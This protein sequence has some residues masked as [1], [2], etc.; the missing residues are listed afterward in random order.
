MY[1]KSIPLVGEKTYKSSARYEKSKLPNVVVFTAVDHIKNAKGFQY[2][3]NRVRKVAKE[4]LGKFLFS[5]A[6]KDDYS[7]AL[8]DYDIPELPGRSDVAVGLQVGDMYY[9]MT[10][11]FS[12]EAL[13]AF[14]EAYKAGTLVGK[15]K[16][17]CNL[18]V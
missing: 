15:Q 2:I 13:K 4:Y 6:N 7:Y 8:A 10:E 1:E 5:V 3:A 12:P 11:A 16:V 18:H 9:R 17:P 14:V